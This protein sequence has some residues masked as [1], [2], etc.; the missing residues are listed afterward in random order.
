L[1]SNFATAITIGNTAV[2]LGNTVTTLNNM[3]LANV[4]ISSG[5][6]TITN[7]AVTTANVSGTANVSTLVVVGNA[8]VG[9]TL[10]ATGATTITAQLTASTGDGTYPIISK[11]TRAFSAGVT[12]PQLGFFGLDST[13]TNNSL[14]AIRALAQASQN[15]TLQ[16]RVLSSGS[17]TTIGTFSS[18]GLAVTGTFSSTLG[19]TIQGLTVG[20]GG[21]A[22]GT[23]TA[24]GVSAIAATATGTYAT[25]IGYSA[26]T[27]L[28]SGL[29]N[30]A[31]GGNS[32]VANQ[33]GS[34][35]S[36]FGLSALGA[37]ISGNSNTAIGVD[38]LRFTTGSNNTAVGVEAGKTNVN[39]NGNTFVGYQAGYTSNYPTNGQIANTFIGYQSGYDVSTGYKNTIIGS[40]T[41][42]TGV[43]GSL[44]IR[45]SNN[46]IVLSDGDGNPRAYWNG[47]SATFN[48]GLTIASTGQVFAGGSSS[49]TSTQ[50]YM[51]FAGT[52]AGAGS[53][54]WYIGQNA[55]RSDGSYAIQNSG[56]TGLYLTNGGTSWTSTSDERLKTDLQP[57]ENAAQKISTLRAVTGRFKTDDEN[58][59]RAFLI[60]QDVQAVLPQAVDA[61]DP[62]K[63]GVQYTDVIPLL[64]AAIKELKAEVDSLKSQLNGA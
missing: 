52:D 33:G 45:T 24:V 35:N 51:Y 25:A 32:L 10:S 15:G 47:A 6:I 16:A 57:I 20:L 50:C 46:Y 59:S 63:L 39:G 55:F 17:I 2:Q 27:A 5:T 26:L 38:A 21:G 22:V 23:N 40:F 54:R 1:D 36:A 29:Y 37:N 30:T 8:T 18:T 7:V 31:V 28:T 9:G 56:G 13:S 3:T 62:E 48:G 61:S 49:G 43:P 4:T 12:G 19:T 34:S 41:G 14:G 64:V 58:V 60:A 42:Y 11:D 44:D 53:V